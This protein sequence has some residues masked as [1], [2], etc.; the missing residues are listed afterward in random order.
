MGG[1]VDSIEDGEDGPTWVTEDVFDV[2]TEHHF[3]EDLTAGETDEG[4]VQGLLEGVRSTTGEVGGRGGE[5]DVVG[6]RD[7][8]ES[9]C[10]I[11]RTAY[12]VDRELVLIRVK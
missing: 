2:V 8:L 10:W 7:L 1:L 3:V 9:R 4:V 6:C 12:E 5:T 11:G